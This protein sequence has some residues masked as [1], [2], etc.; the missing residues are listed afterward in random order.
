MEYKSFHKLG[1]PF[2]EILNLKYSK[3]NRKLSTVLFN[4]PIEITD[5][6]W[7]LHGLKEIFLDEIYKFSSEKIDPVIIDCGSNIGLSIIYFKTLFPKAKIYG[8]EPD[9][10]I[11]KKLNSNLLQFGYSD[12]EIFPKAIWIDESPLYFKRTGSVGGHIVD[13]KVGRGIMIRTKR[14]KDLLKEDI[15]FLKIDIEGAEYDVIID[16]WENLSNVKNIFIE[17]HSFHEKEQMIGEVLQILKKAG[18]KLYLKEAWK[19]MNLPY[20]EKKGLYF[21]LQVNIFGYRR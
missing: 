18:F 2:M 10:E 17:Y 1:I 13:G 7:Y 14:L 21:D 12:I 11:Y 3:N 5:S 20:I 15:D 4:T 9:V 16:C 8:F 19:N 6:F